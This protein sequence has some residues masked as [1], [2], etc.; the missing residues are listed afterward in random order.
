MRGWIY[1]ILMYDKFQ[2]EHNFLMQVQD[3]YSFLIQI[4]NI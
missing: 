1:V 3:F 2:E 4:M